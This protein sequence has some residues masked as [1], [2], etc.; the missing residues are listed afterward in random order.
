MKPFS[1]EQWHAWQ[2]AAHIILS[3]ENVKKLY[4]FLTTDECINWL[5]MNDHKAA[6]RALNQ[7]VKGN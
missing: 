1:F 5:F 7:H 2:G 4:Y 6:A 3:D